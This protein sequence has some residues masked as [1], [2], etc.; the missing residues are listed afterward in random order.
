MH[1][2][3]GD[4]SHSAATPRPQ[5]RPKDSSTKEWLGTLDNFLSF[6]GVGVLHMILCDI[7]STW[8]EV[9]SS[10]LLEQMIQFDW[11]KTGD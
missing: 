1:S 7:V 5:T 8:E 10:E 11:V 9:G 4:P 3:R 6:L 2:A